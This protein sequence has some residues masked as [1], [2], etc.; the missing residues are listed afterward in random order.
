MIRLTVKNQE[1]ELSLPQIIQ[2]VKQLKPEEKNIVRRA[3]DD[4]AWSERVDAV[5]E[6]VWTR[7]EQSPL[8]DEDINAEIESVRQTLFDTRRR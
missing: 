3:L 8:A 2:V 4:R 6:R 1:I 7:V 5:L